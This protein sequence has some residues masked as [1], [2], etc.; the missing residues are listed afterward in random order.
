MHE[1]HFLGS[2]L[3]GNGERR[4]RKEEREVRNGEEMNGQKRGGDQMEE[5]CV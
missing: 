1:K 5:G 3:N 4:R 2:G